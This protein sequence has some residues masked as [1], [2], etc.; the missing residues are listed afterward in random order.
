MKHFVKILICLMVLLSCENEP[1]STRTELQPASLKGGKKKINICHY[2]VDDDKWFVINVNQTAWTDHELHGDVRLDDQDE[3]GY[4]PNNQCGYEGEYGMGDCDDQNV[5][6]NPGE[7]EIIGNNIDDD[8][9]PNTPD[10]LSQLD[11]LKII[12]EEN[13]GKPDAWD[14]NVVNNEPDLNKWEGVRSDLNGN[15][16]H[17]VLNRTQLIVIPKE[18]MYLSNLIVLQI[19]GNNINQIPPEIGTLI[20]LK[21][22]RIIGT[23]ITNLPSELGNLLNLEVLDISQNNLIAIPSEIGNLSSL[24]FLL[25]FKNQLSNLPTEIENLDNLLSLNISS[26]QLRELPPEIGELS[27]LYSLSIS[28]NQFSILPPEIGLL[29][30]LSFFDLSNN[31]FVEL[32]S[33]IGLLSNIQDLYLNDNQLENL[34]KEIGQLTSLLTLEISGNP[35]IIIPKEIC[36]LAP[37]TIILKDVDDSCEQ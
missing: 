34:P 17:L 21:S 11:I 15:I 10:E 14:D 9:N 28:F 18:I 30:N 37:N 1:I 36:A 6:I 5:E 4:V 29:N 2:S 3:D 22:L 24:K 12:H 25:I 31:E 35:I 7:M 13:Y 23:P 8:C 33:E 27:E 19:I 26:N 32:P 20:N 16:T